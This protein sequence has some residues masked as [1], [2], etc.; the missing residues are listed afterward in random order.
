[1][2]NR[3]HPTQ[4]QVF[5]GYLEEKRKILS[6][7]VVLMLITVC[8]SSPLYAF[9]GIK[10]KK[11]PIVRDIQRESQNAADQIVTNKT[12][13]VCGQAFS[14]SALIWGICI[15]SACAAVNVCPAAPA[16]TTKPC[17]ASLKV[18]A[19]SCGIAPAS[20]EA[21]TLIYVKEG[22]GLRISE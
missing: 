14:V 9:G 13:R 1:M 5:N 16:I 22:T 12:L 8:S 19:D 3:Q 2:N 17:E 4:K 10:I 21:A 20:I 18:M 15:G 6:I 11:P 7:L